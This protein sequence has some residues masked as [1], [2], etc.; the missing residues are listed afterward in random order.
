MGQGNSTT[1]MAITELVDRLKTIKELLDQES[2][3][4]FLSKHRSEAQ[5]S[6]IRI[7]QLSSRL[8]NLLNQLSSRL[9]K[10]NILEVTYTSEKDR[11]IRKF[12]S[13]M[14]NISKSEFE[15]LIGLLNEIKPEQKI[16]IL[17]IREIPTFI[18]ELPL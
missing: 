8:K 5:S 13:I 1:N 11:D 9:F 6:R 14:T 2:I 16:S 18:K 12:Q 7:N 17:E 15:Y 4:L 3:K 10:G